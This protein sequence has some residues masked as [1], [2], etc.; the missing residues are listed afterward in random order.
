MTRTPLL[1]LI[2][3]ACGGDP[4]QTKP[5]TVSAGAPSETEELVRSR[6]ASELTEDILASYERDDPPEVA[7]DMVRAEVG[8]ARI[9]FG[10]T[11]I[12]FGD[13]L[14]HPPSLWRHDAP[15][16]GATNRLFVDGDSELRSKDL[17]V[18]L[19]ADRSA[20][21]VSDDLSWRLPA[22][23]RTAVVPMRSTE[24]YAHDGD[25]WILV[26]QHVSFARPLA[27]PT[28]DAPM[29][30]FKQQVVR[31]VADPLSAVLQGALLGRV[32]GTLGT[33]AHLVGPDVGD[34][35]FGAAIASAQ[36]GNGNIRAQERRVGTIGRSVGRATVAYW[37]GDFDVD[38]PGGIGKVPLR[39][40]FVFEKRDG[41][42]VLVQGHLSQPIGDDALAQKV[43]GTA[44]VQMSPLRLDCGA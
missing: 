1:L 33:D 28:G 40:T 8:G 36:I 44:L 23:G 29:R 10:A 5:L 32:R 38:G 43:F 42:W 21:W 14:L 9:G 2:A 20:A 24:L 25:R 35:W 16:P 17:R 6:V 27:A 4:K 11:D 12:V 41:N 3:A 18:V 30:R 13:E 26:F 34:D 19:S 15:K 31:D 37:I 7:T 39:G 22:C